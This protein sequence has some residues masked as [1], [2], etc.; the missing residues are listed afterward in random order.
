MVFAGPHIYQMVTEPTPIELLL[1]TV[2][3]FYQKIM[4]AIALSH[5]Q[6]RSTMTQGARSSAAMVWTN[7]SLV[8]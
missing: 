7:G 2:A 4:Y 1:Q 3:C 5:F 8:S 6:I